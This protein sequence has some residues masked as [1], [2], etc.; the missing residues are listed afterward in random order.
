MSCDARRDALLLFASGLLEEP[1]AAELRAHLAEGCAACGRHLAEARDVLL[2]LEIAA[3]GAE[4]PLA[5]RA[6]LLRRIDRVPR[7]A[8]GAP[9]RALRPRFAPLALAAT[10]AALVAAP[11]GWLVAERRSEARLGAA[12]AELA[13]VRGAL[14]EQLA[15]S[16]EEVGSLDEELAELEVRS[17][18]LRSDLERAG[19]QVAMLSE[20][21]LVTLDLRTTGTQPEARARV[22]WEW[23]DYYCY[24]DAEGLGEVQPPGVYA[25]WLDTEGGNRILAGT[26]APAG[27]RATLW[28]QLPRD[29][30]K[31]V[32]AHITL[33]PEP[34]GPTPAGPVQLSSGVPRHS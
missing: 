5:L 8:A 13:G 7:L 1:E 17:R 23:D 10:L 2:A 22:F 11:L 27:G 24:L 30:G 15:E 12:A 4:P 16:R 33:E 34:P 25:L 28:V 29:M 9:P 26:F 21:G 14:E 32:A 31:A 3:P 6:A 19:R 18:T 20:P